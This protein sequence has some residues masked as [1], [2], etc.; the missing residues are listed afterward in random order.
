[1]F[2]ALCCSN[3]YNKYWMAEWALKARKDIPDTH[4]YAEEALSSL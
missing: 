2:R 4:C 3:V 1:M